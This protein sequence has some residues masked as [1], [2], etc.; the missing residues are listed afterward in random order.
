V[1]F[2]LG[3][4]I[5][6][7]TLMVVNWIYIG[8]SIFNFVSP[9]NISNPVLN[10]QD[11]TDVQANEVADPFMVR[12]NDIWYMFFEVLNAWDMEI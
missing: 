4:K 12:E 8:E 5:C 7:E 9:E 2:L 11:V 10:A 1:V 3:E 6:K